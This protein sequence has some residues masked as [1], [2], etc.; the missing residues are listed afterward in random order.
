MTLEKT[1]T[2]SNG[3]VQQLTNELTEEIIT[4]KKPHV[5]VSFKETLSLVSKDFASCHNREEI[6]RD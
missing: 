6:L 1:S 3:M 4:L 5:D 2:D